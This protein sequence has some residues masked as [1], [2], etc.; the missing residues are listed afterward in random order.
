MKRGLTNE[1]DDFEIKCCNY[2]CLR[3]D[4]TS[5]FTGG[6]AIYIGEDVKHIIKC[7][8]NYQENMWIISIQV[9]QKQMKGIFS[10]LYHSPSRSAADFI[11]ILDDWCE[12]FIEIDQTNMLCG[13]FNIDLLKES[14]YKDKIL[15]T[16]NDRGTKQQ[17]TEPTRI[18]PSSKTLIDYVISNEKIQ[19]IV[20]TDNKI[21]D[22]STIAFGKR[23]QSLQEENESNKC[24]KIVGYSKA[25]F[26][27][28]LE[29]FNWVNNDIDSACSN[30]LQ[31]R[32]SETLSSYVKSVKICKEKDNKWYNSYLNSLKKQRDEAYRLTIFETSE[33]KWRTYT[34][35]RNLYVR[36][37]R[38]AEKLFI[39]DKI[40]QVNGDNRGMW[41]VLK[42]MM[43]GESKTEVKMIEHNG[44]EITN[45]CQIAN[46]LNTFFVSSVTEINQSIPITPMPNN[47]TRC[48]NSCNCIF[49]FDN[50]EIDE[51]EIIL[52]K[53]NS[54]S[55]QFKISSKH[56][57]DALPI[58]GSFLKGIIN[59]SM[60]T[61]T[62]PD[63]WK[64]SIIIPVPKKPK[65]KH[66]VDFRPI[67]TMLSCE[68]LLEK[69]VK[70]QLVKYVETNN[71][72]SQCQSGYREKFSCESALNLVLSKWKERIDRNEWVV[73]VF[74]DFK[75]AF[76]TIDRQILLQKLYIMGIKDNE[77]DWFRSYLCNRKQRT[78][79]GDHMSDETGNYLGVPQ[80]SIL[81]AFLF[82]IYINDI[83][84]VIQN[85]SINLFADDTLIYICG[86]DINELIKKVNSDLVNIFNYLCLNKLKL[87]MEKTKTMVIGK[88]FNSSL[89]DNIKINNVIIE[90]VSIYKYLGIVVDNKLNF[91]ANI[92]NLCKK[93]AKKV[94]VLARTRKNLDYLSSVNIYKTIIAPHFDYCATIL[95]MSGKEELDR[96]Q[97]LQNR[98]MRVILKVN[99]YSK[100]SEMLDTLHF[101][102]VKQR[103]VYNSLILVFKIKKSLMPSYLSDIV[104]LV[105]ENHEY[106]VRSR[107]NFRLYV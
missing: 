38:K 68:K 82:I 15:K 67:N 63:T 14:F 89:I 61:G 92:D 23:E 91:K 98:A 86:T 40:K 9:K 90:K 62:F 75:R 13:D 59:N 83:Q 11:H 26:Q 28:K 51:I 105:A 50:L 16:L 69:T 64:E 52:K 107:D 60:K 74:L 80:G 58:I 94:G 95:F 25:S 54:K 104:S 46:I 70:D 22:H 37:L 56:I 66:P 6:V 84:S 85:C 3:C 87:N 106:P 20:L 21:S 72:L 19:A 102:N 2:I 103:I 43:Q 17:V 65:A 29:R 88:K 5:R 36:E 81:G 41:K 45:K 100:I 31:K 71:L 4:S 97:K 101:M 1:I 55:D 34:M 49:K 73:T 79:I 48:L 99:K 10:V 42:S 93:V 47:P 12:E 30:I 53:M 24:E 27:E 96:M 76:E 57:L 39:A 8:K 33:E 7:N 18:T 77:L 35:K 32:L 44:V 78:R